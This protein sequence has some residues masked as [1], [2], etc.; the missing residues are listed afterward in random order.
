[1]DGKYENCFIMLKLAFSSKYPCPQVQPHR[2][3]TAIDSHSNTTI[4]STVFSCSFV[5]DKQRSVA[6]IAQKL[7]KTHKPIINPNQ[8]NRRRGRLC[9]AG[10]G[11]GEALLI[12]RS[13]S[14]TFFS[15]W[16]AMTHNINGSWWRVQSAHYNY[17]MS[18][19]AHCNHCNHCN[20][21]LSKHRFFL[22]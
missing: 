11:Q 4:Y 10:N 12:Q 7:T 18:P 13:E 8:M 3:A 17:L 5:I 6:T 1:M 22:L 15:T 21:I 16:T 2:A 19:A 20:I 9:S 14:V